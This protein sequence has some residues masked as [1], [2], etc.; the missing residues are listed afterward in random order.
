MNHLLIFLKLKI[1]LEVDRTTIGALR[2]DILSMG[3]KSH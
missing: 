2:K 1:Y 3:W